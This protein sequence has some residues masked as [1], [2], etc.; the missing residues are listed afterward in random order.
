MLMSL[1]L[2]A[3]MWDRVVTN[4]HGGPETIHHYYFQATMRQNAPGYCP[5]QTEPCGTIVAASPVPFGPNFGDPSTGSVVST[6]VDPVAYPDMLPLPPVG[7]LA[8]WPWP[9]ADNPSPV[10]AVDMNG[11]RSDSVCQ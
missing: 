6:W 5:T 7:G 9:T 11:N 8:A 3:W 2:L 1:L 10:V 4:C